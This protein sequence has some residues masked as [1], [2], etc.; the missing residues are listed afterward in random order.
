MTRARQGSIITPQ[1][2]QG[3]QGPQGVPGEVT[4]AELDAAI[5][6]IIQDMST[7]WYGVT[8]PTDGSQN[9]IKT[10]NPVFHQNHP[11]LEDLAL[12]LLAD[13]LTENS[14][15]ATNWNPEIPSG[16]DLSGAS[17]QVMVRF[18]KF[19]YQEV[20]N[21][22]NELTELR[23]SAKKLPGFSIHPFFTDGVN[24][25]DYAYISAYEAGDDGGTKLK[26]ASSVAPLTGVNLATFRSRAV[27]RG[28]GW[29]AYDHWAQHLIQMLFYLYYASLDSQGKLP[30]YTETSTY[31]DLYKRNTGRSDGLITMNGSVDVDLTGTDS[32][33]SGI[34]ASGGKIANRFLFMENI[35]GHIWKMLDGISFDGRVASEFNDAY[36]CKEPAKYSSLDADIL[37]D[38]EAQGLDI[39]GGTTTYIKTVY[40]GF[41]PKTGGANSSTYFGDLFWSYLD[42]IGR[43][44][45]RLVRAGGSLTDG[46]RAGV[47]CRHSAYDLGL[48]YSH[49]GS[50]LCAKN[51]GT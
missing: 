29:H 39:V 2:A 4:Q 26:S 50:R 1:G 8:I 37:A 23:W 32:D 38:Y 6:S 3:P 42:D 31:D 43:D 13:D 19:Y 20:F 49:Y 46:G 14:V 18:K 30:G 34:V 24:E 33:L 22:S 7:E 11:F 51:F 17:G 15:L 10:G 48:A 36:I 40:A 45:F 47:A 35:F 9:C 12:V 41:I 44:Y 5:E 27:A 16:A 21:A 25:A 28:T